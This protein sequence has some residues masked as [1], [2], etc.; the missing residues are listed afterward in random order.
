MNSKG[1]TL[2]ETV[3]S[4]S[5]FLLVTLTVLPILIQVRIEQKDLSTKRQAI[6][7]L[8]DD[9]ISWDQPLDVLPLTYTHP[10]HPSLVFKFTIKNHL[11]KGCTTTFNKE[12]CFYGAP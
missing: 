10:D 12:V 1:F 8:H 3:F 4:F 2:A 6:S 5:L 7:T 11:I 9:V